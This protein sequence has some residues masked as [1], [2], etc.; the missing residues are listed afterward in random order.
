MRRL[1]VGIFVGGGSVRMGGAPKG[2]LRTESG[3]SIVERL[4]RICGERLSG[5]PI[6]LVGEARAYSHLMLP[7]LSDERTGIGPIGGL[8][9]LLSAAR[10]L[11][12][13][14]VIALACDLPGLTAD[15][16]KRLAAHPESAAVAARPEGVWQPLCARY[17]ADAALGVTEKL[18]LNHE[19]ALYRVL[20][21]L[22]AEELALGP[23]DVPA[24]RDWDEPSDVD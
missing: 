24:L 12:A 3:E 9:A 5:V 21:E 15:L 7:A 6:V 19:R 13:E 20:E 17:R 1:L 14:S 11:G 18:I 16:L 8:L 23:D 4:V 10:E 22:G 2:L